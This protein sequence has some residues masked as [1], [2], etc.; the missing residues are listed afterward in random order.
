VTWDCRYTYVLYCPACTNV[1]AGGTKAPRSRWVSL[2][3]QHERECP[4]GGHRLELLAIFSG[5]YEAS[6]QDRFH[7]RWRRGEWYAYV[8]PIRAWLLRCPPQFVFYRATD[9]PDVP[10]TPS[11]PPRKRRHVDLRALRARARHERET[12]GPMSRAWP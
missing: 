7:A 3:S 10:T 1:K 8:E 9:L 2:E 11:P 12:Q 6:F 5:K 4:N